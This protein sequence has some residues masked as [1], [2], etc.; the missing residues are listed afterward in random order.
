MKLRL[1]FFISML[2]AFSFAQEITG[3]FGIKFGSSLSEL[4]VIGTSKTTDG[5]TLY[6]VDPPIKIKALSEYYVMATPIS[7]K[8]FSI[9]G[10]DEKLQKSE[11][12]TRL[13]A[14]L[15]ALERKYK[16]KRE[17]MLSI[18]DENYGVKKG[19]VEVHVRCSDEFTDYTLYVQYYHNSLMEQAEKEKIRLKSKEIDESGL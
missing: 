18:F 9:W 8:V 7:K 11:C 19:N 16:I 10:L 5:D 2:A 15:S 1:L 13:K 14:I 3:A 12:L 4:K 6:M 17:K